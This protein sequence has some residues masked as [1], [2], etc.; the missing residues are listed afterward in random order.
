A[1]GFHVFE[2]VQAYSGFQ[3]DILLSLEEMERDLSSTFAFTGMGFEG[4]AQKITFPAVIETIEVIE[5]E[6]TIASSVGQISYYLKGDNDRKIL[7]RDQLDYFQ[8]ASKDKSEDDRSGFFAYVKDLKFSYY[9]LDAESQEGGWE[10]SWSTEEAL[11]EAVKIELTYEDRGGDIELVRTVFVPAI[12]VPGE[13]EE[14]GDD[15]EE[16]GEGEV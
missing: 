11:P 9:S 12:Q 14:S 3:A 15:G 16:E 13:I 2:R 4:G 8:A 7:M 6:E 5:D 10:E 1:S